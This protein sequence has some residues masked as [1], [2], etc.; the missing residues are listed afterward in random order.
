MDTGIF[1]IL[2]LQ[3]LFEAMSKND[4]QQVFNLLY[5]LGLQHML[6]EDVDKFLKRILT[7]AADVAY[8]SS[9]IIEVLISYCRR[10]DGGILSPISRLFQDESIDDNVLIYTLANY[11]YITF[12]DIMY[13]YVRYD[14]DFNLIIT[15]ERIHNIFGPQD[16]GVYHSIMNDAK[17]QDNSVVVSYI[18]G[19]LGRKS[20]PLQK[21]EWVDNFT[22]YKDLPHEEDI[23]NPFYMYDL[24]TPSHDIILDLMSEGLENNP[25]YEEIKANNSIIINIATTEEKKEL[26]RPYLENKTLMQRYDDVTLF[27]IYGPINPVLEA[28]LS[29]STPLSEFRMLTDNTFNSVESSTGVIIKNPDWFIGYCQNCYQK[30]EKRCYAIRIPRIYGG[31]IGCFCSKR[32]ILKNDDYFDIEKDEPNEI[33]LNMIELLESDLVKYGIQDRIY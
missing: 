33:Q 24:S 32:C 23:I 19:L 20:E 25:N 6:V 27:R 17:E 5:K 10:D 26:I 21:P 4:N 29:L 2:T 31:F 18:K 22:N 11:R 30:I 13:E 16:T 9:G 14:R 3:K 28:G 8:D 7:Y 15:F 12:F 1:V